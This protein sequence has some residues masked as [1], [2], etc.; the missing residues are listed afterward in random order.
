MVL[1]LSGVLCL[2]LCVLTLYKTMPREG[3]PP[4]AWVRTETRAVSM[5][6]LVLILLFGGITRLAK[7]IVG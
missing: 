1:A 6:M 2:L 3:K 4:S 5:A 7:G